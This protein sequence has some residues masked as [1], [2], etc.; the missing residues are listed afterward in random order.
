M[1]LYFFIQLRVDADKSVLLAPTIKLMSM[2]A[3]RMIEN[4]VFFSESPKRW[5]ILQK[6]SEGAKISLKNQSTT[7]WPSREKATYC[8]LMNLPKI[9]AALVEIANAKE[10]DASSFDANNLAKKIS[11]F[12]FIYGVVVWHNILSKINFVSK[13]LQSQ[14]ID[15]THCSKLIENLNKHFKAVRESNVFIDEWF[16]KAEQMQKEFSTEPTALDKMAT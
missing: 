7:R 4:F 3:Q 16:E 6:F 1:C 10:P 11:K 15:I 12:K 14:S 2:F 13:S 5:A 8:L 9:H